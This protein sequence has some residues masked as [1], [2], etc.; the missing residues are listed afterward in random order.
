LTKP[1]ELKP[2]QIGILVPD[3]KAAVPRYAAIFGVREWRLWTYGP[4]F[5]PELTYRDQPGEFVMRLALSD[6]SPQ[7]ELIEPL[8]GPSIYE[9]WLRDNRAGVHHIGTFVASLD[10]AAEA[11][12]EAGYELVQAGRGYGAKGDGGFAYFDTT[13]DLGI[14]TEVLEIPTARRPPEATWRNGR[15]HRNSQ[16]VET[17]PAG[18]ASR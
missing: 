5:V 10:S 7:L 13:R 15:W 8:R 2:D 16:Q 11:M 4:D 3:I 14:I 1:L 18:V 6:S 17:P 12:R 9:E